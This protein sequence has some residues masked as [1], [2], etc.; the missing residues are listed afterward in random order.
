M[1][2]SIGTIAGTMYD[3][4]MRRQ[5]ENVSQRY[6]GS[7]ELVAQNEKLFAEGY[8]PMHPNDEYD[9]GVDCYIRSELE[10]KTDGL[11]YEE[12]KIDGLPYEEE[13]TDGLEEKIDGLP[14]EEEKTDGLPYEEEKT[15]GLPYEEEKI[16]APL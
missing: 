6:A 1:T 10:E 13:K 5:S 12:E 16:D 14:Y 11:P 3:H 2:G 9:T 4:Y 15:D 8:D 7:K